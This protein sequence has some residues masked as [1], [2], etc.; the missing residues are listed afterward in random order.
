MGIIFVSLT[1]S[2]HA[3]MPAPVSQPNPPDGVLSSTLRSLRNAVA[4][5]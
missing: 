2:K 5:F 1:E 4:P 3:G